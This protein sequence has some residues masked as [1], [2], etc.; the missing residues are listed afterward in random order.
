MEAARISLANGDSDTHLRK[1]YR[2]ESQQGPNEEENGEGDF[3]EGRRSILKGLSKEKLPP[4]EAH[5]AFEENICMVPADHENEINI[6]SDRPIS[7]DK[8]S[9]PVKTAEDLE[10]ESD[11][12]TSFST[13]CEAAKPQRAH[14]D[15]FLRK[16]LGLVKRAFDIKAEPGRKTGFRRIDPAYA[17]KIRDEIT[18]D[19]ERGDECTGDSSYE[20]IEELSGSDIHEV[21]AAYSVR[22]RRRKRAKSLQKQR[23]EMLTFGKKKFEAEKIM[24]IFCAL[25]IIIGYPLC[26]YL[27]FYNK[28]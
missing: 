28:N 21:D 11:S 13:D 17:R 18:R 22:R 8:E 24:I 1:R 7:L 2:T 15:A 12:A 9:E 25:F 10:E 27:Q 4:D 20:T 16:G 19:L 23:L 26:Y 5:V 3:R 14:A 6:K